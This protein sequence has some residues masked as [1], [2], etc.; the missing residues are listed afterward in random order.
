MNEAA[1]IILAGGE[2]KRM[3]FPKLLLPFDSGKTF[4]EQIADTY[5]K[6]I[7]GEVI[8]VINA[9][10]L[11]AHSTFFSQFKDLIIVPNHNPDLGRTY[12]IQLGLAKT[13]KRKI[14]IQNT[15]NPFVSE[16]S[17]LSMLELASKDAYV[18]PRSNG[19]GGHPILICG[20]VI[21]K[22]VKADYDK[23][24]KS[25]LADS[26]RIDWITDDASMLVNIDTRDVYKQYFPNL[27]TEFNNA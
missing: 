10:V 6:V 27:N 7:Q 20:N 2:S 3:G 21:D 16:K 19:K 14:F 5:A 24:L 13:Q 23:S 17:L 9:E 15:D 4:I 25:I 1:A 26:M 22:I 12:S 8:L 18:S 11:K